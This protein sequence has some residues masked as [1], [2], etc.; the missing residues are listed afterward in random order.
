MLELTETLREG[1]LGP[2]LTTQLVR[3]RGGL[4]ALP[5][6][7]VPCTG[8]GYRGVR[9]ARAAHSAEASSAGPA[10]PVLHYRA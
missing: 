1:V 3:P 5:G 6:S 4:G 10:G 9:C 7:A 2:E 8:S